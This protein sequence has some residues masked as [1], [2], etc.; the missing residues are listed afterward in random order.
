MPALTSTVTKFTTLPGQW[1]KTRQN[2]SW[3]LTLKRQPAQRSLHRNRSMSVVRVLPSGSAISSSD[4]PQNALYTPGI[5]TRPSPS[6]QDFASSQFS[7]MKSKPLKRLL[8]CTRSSRKVIQLYVMIRSDLDRDTDVS[9]SRRSKRHKV[10]RGG[11]KRA[12]ERLAMMAAKVPF[13]LTRS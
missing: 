8:W 4:I 6:G 9:M 12:H 13:F 10:K 1:T 2:R 3:L 5:T 7:L 11:S